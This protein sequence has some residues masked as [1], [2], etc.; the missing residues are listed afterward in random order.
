MRIIEDVCA[1]NVGS[2]ELLAEYVFENQQTMSTLE[3]FQIIRLTEKV[4]SENTLLD[5]ELL[6][7]EMTKTPNLSFLNALFE[8]IFSCNPNSI[9]KEYVASYLRRVI[10]MFSHCEGLMDSEQCGKLIGLYRLSKC[11][12]IRL[13]CIKILIFFD[14]SVRDAHLTEKEKSLISAQMS[15]RMCQRTQQTESSEE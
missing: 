7:E 10:Q 4:V 12:K 9:E 8:A 2:V 5:L 6:L 14:S 15:L 3:F 1:E 13:L 11:P